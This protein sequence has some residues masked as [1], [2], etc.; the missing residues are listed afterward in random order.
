[1]ELNQ[2]TV[3]E[4]F[5]YNK[6]TGEFTRRKNN[7]S[8]KAGTTAGYIKKSDGY[9]YLFI[10]NKKYLA[11]RIAWLYVYGNNPKIYVD[12]INGVRNDNRI[13]NLRE[14]N[15]IQNSCNKR[16]QH[17]NT[18]GYKGVCFIKSVGKWRARIGYNCKKIDIGF[19]STAKEA[20]DAY[21]EK[22]IELHGEFA[23]L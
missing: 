10:N 11:H 15:Y 20:A 9:V 1:M 22:A 8:H 16:F 14:A 2:N 19:F 4:L 21:K 13:E 17:N 3:Q 5:L 7:C 18:S 12:H 6:H 23:R